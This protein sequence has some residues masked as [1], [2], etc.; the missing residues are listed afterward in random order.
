QGGGVVDARGLPSRALE[1]VH[2]RVQNGTPCLDPTIVAA[3]EDSALMD[4]DRADRNTALRQPL[5]RLV[6]GGLKKVIH[7]A[8]P[9]AA[10]G[11]HSV[12]PY[13]FAVV[14]WTT[15]T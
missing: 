4:Q 2:F 9:G 5:A 3:P 14:T 11:G 12:E 8:T 1:G 15:A 10:L 7:A 6:E 13:F